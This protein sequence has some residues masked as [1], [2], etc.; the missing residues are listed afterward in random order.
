MD[1]ATTNAFLGIM[2]AVSIL[3]A[4][5]L[6]AA[7]VAGVLAYRRVTETL[8]RVETRHVAPAITR[9][10]A[11]L[12]DI[13]GVTTVARNAVEGADSSVRRGITWVL[14]QFRRRPPG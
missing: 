13:R 2:A 3:E 5:A 11:V 12:D 4:L 14:R 9:V 8:E 10:N 7:V 1:L 6:I